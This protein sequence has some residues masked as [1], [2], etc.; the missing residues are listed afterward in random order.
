MG[1]GQSCFGGPTRW[2]PDERL[3]QA[4]RWGEAAGSRGRCR[5]LGASGATGAHLPLPG[6][7]VGEALPKGRCSQ[8][9][10]SVCSLSQPSVP[11]ARP[12]GNG[13][14]GREVKEGPWSLLG[15]QALRDSGGH[16]A[17]GPPGPRNEEDQVPGGGGGE[18]RPTLPCWQKA[19][20]QRKTLVFSFINSGSGPP[21]GWSLIRN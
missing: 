4:H 17:A 18:Q 16:R 20:V 15:A 19:H 14:V 10:W 9:T 7:P 21:R 12:S 3:R 5:S 1:K 6:G 8:R 11:G 13:C 2:G